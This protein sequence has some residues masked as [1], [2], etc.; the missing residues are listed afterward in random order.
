[1]QTWIPQNG[2]INEGVPQGCILGTPLIIPS[3][4]TG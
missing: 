1:M 2:R 3:G 4:I